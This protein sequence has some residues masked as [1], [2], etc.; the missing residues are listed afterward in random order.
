MTME[1]KLKLQNEG[2]FEGEKR[3]FA[4][5]LIICFSSVIVIMPYVTVVGILFYLI[6][7]VL[8]WK[9]R[10]PKNQKWQWSLLPILSVVFIYKLIDLVIYCFDKIDYYS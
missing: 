3:Q 1:S 4:A 7:V 2:W 10:L 8:L 9:T 5:T 6:G